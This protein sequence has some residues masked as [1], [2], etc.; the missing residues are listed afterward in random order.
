MKSTGVKM[1]QIAIAS[2]IGLAFMLG[3]VNNVMAI[4]NGQQD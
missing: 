2:V 4:T 1:R 3:M